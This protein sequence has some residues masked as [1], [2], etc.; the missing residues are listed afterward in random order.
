MCGDNV[1]FGVHGV[2]D[3]DEHWIFIA[4]GEQRMIRAYA[5]GAVEN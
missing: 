3:V 5:L 2:E 1:A 4:V